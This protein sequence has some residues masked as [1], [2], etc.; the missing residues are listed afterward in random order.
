ME[1]TNQ[2]LKNIWVGFIVLFLFF[3]NTAFLPQSVTFTL[4]LTPVWLYLIAVHKRVRLFLGLMIPLLLF[5]VLHFSQGVAITRYIISDAIIVCTIAFLIVANDYI[6][7]TS[8]NWDKI[9]RNITILNFTLTLLSI[10]ILFIP[11]LKPLVWYTLPISEHLDNLPRLKLFTSEASHYS[12]LFCPLAIYF[13]S[14][15]LFFK[16]KGVLY[17]FLIVS[18][19]LI[20]SFSFGVLGALLM[21]T[22]IVLVSY[23]SR[24]F[25]NTRR[26]NIFLF[27]F[28][29]LV[30]LLIVLFV[31]FPDNPVFLRIANI[32]HG[33]DTS[34]RGRTYEAFILANK[35]IQQKSML[36]GIGPGQIKLLGRS[37]VIE[38]YSYTRMPDVIRIPNASAETIIYFGYVG[39]VIRLLI[40]IFF[41]FRTKVYANPFRL[42]LFV[43]IFIYQFTGS[44]ITNTTEYLI[45]LLVFSNIFPD[46]IK[47]KDFKVTD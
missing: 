45:W 8:V 3:F 37:I 25:H 11:V 44:Y 21:S 14:R 39:L 22:V 24:I 40:E 18:I 2:H 42:W 34:A 6:N 31:F 20:L 43:F 38:Y 16:G 46:F 41:F 7:D 4:L 32:Y 28:I 27:I 33:D 17:N 35:I 29:L 12:L 23:S 26:K 10:F 47:K 5:A 1:A 36:W 30:I 15:M 19:P 9:F 13:Y